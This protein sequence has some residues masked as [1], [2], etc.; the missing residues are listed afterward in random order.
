MKK[1]THNEL[2][3]YTLDVWGNEDDG[4]EVNNMFSSGISL[5]KDQNDAYYSRMLTK[6]FPLI[7][8]FTIVWSDDGYAEVN[9]STTNEPLLTIME[10]P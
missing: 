7:G 3:I 1:V 10:R 6:Y 4:F 8:K 2:M 9:C 5:L